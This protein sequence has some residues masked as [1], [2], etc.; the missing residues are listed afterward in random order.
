MK[1]GDIVIV[2]FGINIIQNLDD[3]T[4]GHFALIWGQ[5]GHNFIVIPLTKKTA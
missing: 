5:Q 3:D 1:Q 4:N 2:D